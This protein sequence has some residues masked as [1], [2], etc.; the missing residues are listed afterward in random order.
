M[1]VCTMSDDGD[2]CRAIVLVRRCFLGPIGVYDNTLEITVNGKPTVTGDGKWVF[3][4]KASMAYADGKWNVP[5]AAIQEYR[6]EIHTAKGCTTRDMFYSPAC[7][8]G[9]TLSNMGI[10]DGDSYGYPSCHITGGPGDDA[11]FRVCVVYKSAP[12]PPTAP[13]AKVC[14]LLVTYLR[15]CATFGGGI[16]V[17]NTASGVVVTPDLSTGAVPDRLAVYHHT[18]SVDRVAVL[19]LLVMAAM[20]HANDTVVWSD[21]IWDTL[22]GNDIA[23][24]ETLHTYGGVVALFAHVLTKNRTEELNEPLLNHARAYANAYTHM[25]NVMST[26]SS[27]RFDIVRNLLRCVIVQH[28]PP[29]TGEKLLD[30]AVSGATAVASN[31]AGG[32]VAAGSVFN[33]VTNLFGFGASTPATTAS[34]PTPAPQRISVYATL[35]EFK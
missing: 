19:R 34:A 13:A 23:I 33:T 11:V 4:F 24:C 9:Q 5:A 17:W 3:V 15:T 7:D 18:L 8:T 22:G 35:P 21:A 32:V 12:I 31:L 10:G 26:P 20:Y 16:H 27:D 28:N 6:C 29:S 25:A 14:N 30:A 2:V 1:L